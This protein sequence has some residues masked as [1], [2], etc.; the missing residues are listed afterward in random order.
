MTGLM[1]QPKQMI[2]EPEA[3]GPQRLHAAIAYSLN[4]EVK[5]D[6]EKIELKKSRRGTRSRRSDAA[7]IPT[8]CFG[9]PE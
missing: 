5:K 4:G 8:Q 3:V 6:D 2:P 9:S 7:V 1:C